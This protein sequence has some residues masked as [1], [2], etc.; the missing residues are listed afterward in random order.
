MLVYAAALLM[1]LSGLSSAMSSALANSL[2]A[3]MPILLTQ[4][5]LFHAGRRR[6]LR[7]T[8]SALL[9]IVAILSWNNLLGSGLQLINM[10]APSLLGVGLFLYGGIRLLRRPMKDARRASHLLAGLLIVCAVQ[11]FVRMAVLWPLMDDVGRSEEA[12]LSVDLFAVLQMLVSMVG[13]L[14]LY[15]IELLKIEHILLSLAQDDPLTRLANR[16]SIVNRFEELLSL[17]RRVERPLAI[18]MFD[19]DF[20][21]KVNDTQGHEVGDEVLKHVAS[22]LSAVKRREDF[23]GRIGGQEFVLLLPNTDI[24]GSKVIAERMRKLVGNSPLHA[25]ETRVEITIS[26]GAAAFPQDGETWDQIFGAADQRLNR[27]KAEGR[28]RVTIS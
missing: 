13:V 17:A 11:W 9:V 6:G 2:I 27:S 24:V 14:S 8:G 5:V 4:A 19:I 25:E 15:W 26:G 28:D 1:P 12:A 3:A 7:W 21:K 16:R 23:L 20:F 10:A 18:V 22:R